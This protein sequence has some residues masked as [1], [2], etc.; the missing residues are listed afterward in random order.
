[1]ARLV[2][3]AR[4]RTSLGC[5]YPDAEVQALRA[6]MASGNTGPAL[7]TAGPGSGLTTLIALLVSEV[8][9][10]AVWVGC[11][12]P[13]L[14]AL[15]EQAASSPVTVTCRRK[16]IVVDE[17]EAM[18]AGG[19][20]SPLS[21]ATAFARCNPPVPMLFAGRATR[22]QKSLEFAKKWPQFSLG[23]PS[24][25]RVAA[26]LAAVSRQHGIPATEAALAH[27]ASAARGDLRAALIALDMHARAPRPSAAGPGDV[28]AHDKD[29]A[30]DALDLVE[31]VLRGE[32]GRT[33]QDCLKIFGMES[34]VV[35]MGLYENYLA[36]L[37]PQDAGAAF[38]AAEGFSQADVLDRHLYARQAWDNLEAYGVCCV[39]VPSLSLCRRR[40]RPPPPSFGVTKFGTVWSK[41]YNMCAKT[42]HVRAINA[43]LAEAGLQPHDA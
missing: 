18:A 3:L 23:R 39:A 11:A 12:T 28:P 31:A 16:I 2:D 7:A 37:G 13:R 29:E 27:L 6:W 22:S 15:L 40:R 30:T 20:T 26:Y 5:L 19:D 17:I 8:G 36:S 43:A 42:K 4:P 10:E 14:K 34:A 41:V 25:A 1:M 38:D 9:L 35:P 21:E 32:R 24:A 33:V